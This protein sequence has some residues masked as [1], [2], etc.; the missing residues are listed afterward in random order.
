MDVDIDMDEAE[1]PKTSKEEVNRRNDILD[2]VKDL[3]RNA[4]VMDVANERSLDWIWSVVGQ[5][6]LKSVIANDMLLAKDGNLQGPTSGFD[7]SSAMNQRLVVGNIL[8]QVQKIHRFFFSVLH[9][10]NLI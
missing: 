5:L 2:R 10:T 8:T 9:F 4:D 1:K 3:T 7:L 6:R